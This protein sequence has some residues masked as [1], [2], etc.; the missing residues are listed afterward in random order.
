ELADGLDELAAQNK[1]ANEALQE[2]VDAVPDSTITEAD[3]E[4]LYET[5]ADPEVVEELVTT[6]E[7][8]QTVKAVYEEVVDAFDAVDANL[9]EF[10]EATNEVADNIRDIAE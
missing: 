4:A 7:A 2:A 8:A 6:Y 10:S 3:I 1:Q 9:D 5:D